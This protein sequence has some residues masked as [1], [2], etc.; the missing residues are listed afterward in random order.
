[1]ATQKAPAINAG[2]TSTTRSD[3]KSVASRLVL[4]PGRARLRLA[5]TQLSLNWSHTR[6]EHVCWLG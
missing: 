4:T 5:I 6:S 2:G 1:M 3:S